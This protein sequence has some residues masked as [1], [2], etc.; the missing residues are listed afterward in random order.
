MRERVSTIADRK[1]TQAVSRDQLSDI[2]SHPYGMSSH[3]SLHEADFPISES[4][5]IITGL[6]A[7]CVPRNPSDTF[8]FEDYSRR[9]GKGDETDVRSGAQEVRSERSSG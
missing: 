4:L 8:A 2:A 6:T 1:I 5:R 9:G 3:L 7:D